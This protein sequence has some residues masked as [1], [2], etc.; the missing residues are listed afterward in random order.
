MRESAGAIG[1]ILA[2][3]EC[4]YRAPVGFP[5]TIFASARCI[6]LGRSSVTLA[7]R[8]WSVR[9]GAIVAEGELVIVMRDY[10]ADCSVAI[11]EVIRAAIEAL[12]DPGQG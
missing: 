9:R 7:N 3:I 10:R 8:V 1:P 6:R 2:R 12:D 4:D 5:D 11:P